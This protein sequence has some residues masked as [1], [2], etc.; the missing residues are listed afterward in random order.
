MR[1]QLL[2]L[3]S[4]ETLSVWDDLIAEIDNLYD[5][6]R[7]WNKGFCDWVIEKKM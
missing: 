5:V 2:T 1:E 4:E 3:L 6:D 7:L